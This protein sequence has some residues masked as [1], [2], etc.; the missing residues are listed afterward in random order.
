MTGVVKKEWIAEAPV[1][2]VL[3]ALMEFRIRVKKE[4][5][6]EALVIPA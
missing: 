5:I 3:P 4:W 2:H 6:A 1:S